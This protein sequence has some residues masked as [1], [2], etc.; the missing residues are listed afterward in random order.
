MKI[1][2]HGSSFVASR[3]GWALAGGWEECVTALSAYYQPIKTFASRF[4]DLVAQVKNLGF[5]RMDVWQPGVLNWQWA[6]EAHI[7]LAAGILREHQVETVSLAGEFGITRAEFESACRVAVGIGASLLSG[8][9]ALLASDRSFVVDRLEQYDLRL[10]IENEV[11]RTPAEILSQIGDGA[12]GRIGTALDTGWY[13]THGYDISRAVH[14]MTPHILH[15][16]L[17]DV[18]PGPEHVNCGYGQGC[19]DLE[20]CVRALVETGYEGVVSVENHTLDHDPSDDLISARLWLERIL[21]QP[22]IS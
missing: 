9:T 15:V 20:G 8:T 17:K 21:N 14:D 3:Y 1:A 18:L 22:V 13:A 12:G 2:L 11:E 6:S 7:L 16:H 19:V 5:K 4:S 10:A